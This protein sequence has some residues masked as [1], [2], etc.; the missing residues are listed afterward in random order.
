MLYDLAT[1]TGASVTATDGEIGSVRNFLFD[2]RTWM[3]RYIVVDVRR[4]LTRRDVVLA[5]AAVDRP[6]CANKTFRVN[7]T[8]DQVNHSPA[9]DAEKP[10]SH[11]QEVAMMEY[12]GR[13]AYW[14]DIKSGLSATMPTGMEYPSDPHED[15]HLRSVW[16]LH[17]YNVC[18]TADEVG[19]LK[20]FVLDANSWH[21]GYLDIKMGNWLQNRSVL[22][23]THWVKSI[24]WAHHRVDLQQTYPE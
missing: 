16:G 15:A 6:D 9:V 5:T 13:F 22:V 19:R 10:V 17:G 1:L 21:L 3:I 24:S 20:G 11:Q 7:L 18:S 2:D 14:L 4:W 12:F 23:P 8:L